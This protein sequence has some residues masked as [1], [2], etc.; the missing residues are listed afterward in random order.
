MIR[1]TVNV[2]VHCDACNHSLT[3]GF[4]DRIAALVAVDDAVTYDGWARRNGRL[5]C[6]LCTARAICAF[7]GHEFRNCTDYG[8]YG[9]GEDGTGGWRYCACD[10]S[11]P[12]HRDLEPDPAGGP[13]CGMAW[14]LCGSCDH[15][16][17]QHV[18]ALTTKVQPGGYLRQDV[19]AG[20]A[21][22]HHQDS[23]ENAMVDPVHPSA[24]RA[25]ATTAGG[26]R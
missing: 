12:A 1:T 14:R 4:G 26:A 7:H 20:L 21:P 17:E 6:P 5:L 2:A 13:G 8:P 19:P 3:P 9:T 25:P 23:Q 16:D 18:T 22:T 24:G 11:I 10:R 15:I